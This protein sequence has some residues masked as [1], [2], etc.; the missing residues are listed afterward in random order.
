MICSDGQRACL[1]CRPSTSVL[2]GPVYTLEP[3]VIPIPISYPDLTALAVPFPT[4]FSPPLFPCRIAHAGIFYPRKRFASG[5]DLAFLKEHRGRSSNGTPVPDW[6]WRHSDVADSVADLEPD[7]AV[8]V[9]DLR[10][11][12]KNVQI[13]LDAVGDIRLCERIFDNWMTELDKCVANRFSQPRVPSNDNNGFT[14][15]RATPRSQTNERKH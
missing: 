13:I 4:H 15:S 14:E 8:P 2:I 7:V 9:D 10:P 12:A 6:V 11:R 1:Q 5:L 3:R